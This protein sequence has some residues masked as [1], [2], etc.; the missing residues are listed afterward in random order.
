MKNLVLALSTWWYNY[1][2]LSGYVKYHLQGLEGCINTRGQSPTWSHKG[3]LIVQECKLSFD[4]NLF[5]I[6]IINYV[7]LLAEK[8]EQIYELVSLFDCFHH[9]IMAYWKIVIFFSSFCNYDFETLFNICY[10]WIMFISRFFC[11]SF[12]LPLKV[13]VLVF[14]QYWLVDD[15]APWPYL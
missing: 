3:T 8:L 9:D 4:G 2:S 15:C 14:L 7:S 5:Y 6:G 12:L 13:L 11:A 1:N 10:L